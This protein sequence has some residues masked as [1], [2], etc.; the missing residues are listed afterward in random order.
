MSVTPLDHLAKLLHALRAA[1]ERGADR[2]ELLAQVDLLDSACVRALHDDAQLTI[3][4]NEQGERLDAAEGA[5]EL[6]K[7]ESNE[8]DELRNV[9]AD[10]G[11]ERPATHEH[12]VEWLRRKLA[13]EPRG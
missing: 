4:F 8:L 6:L 3:D 1:I 13:L 11:L 9:L 12:A 2:S 7:I 5:I 10:G